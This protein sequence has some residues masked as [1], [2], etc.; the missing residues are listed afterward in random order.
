MLCVAYLPSGLFLQYNRLG[1]YS[2]GVDIYASPVQQTLMHARST[3]GPIALFGAAMSLTLVP[4]VISWHF[5]EKPA[6]RLAHQRPKS[7]PAVVS[8]TSDA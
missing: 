2:W 6:T 3:L 1:D 7:P 4:A 5:I 8:A